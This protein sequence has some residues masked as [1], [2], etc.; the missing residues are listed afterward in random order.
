MRSS[1]SAA[2]RINRFIPYGFAI[3]FYKP[4]TM[5]KSRGNKAY[6]DDIPPL[7]LQVAA[8]LADADN[9]SAP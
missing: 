7:K 3:D 1:P 9:E 6:L 4:E 5:T 2:R 8:M